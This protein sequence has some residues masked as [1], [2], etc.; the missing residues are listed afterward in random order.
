MPK[1]YYG[2]KNEPAFELEQS[3]NLIVVRTRS[4]KSLTR[5]V[6]SVAQPISAELS[7]GALVVSY[8]EVGVEVYRVPT[9]RHDRSMNDRKAALRAAPDVQFAGGVLVDPT[10][11]Q[12]VL[13]TENIFI[14]F[15]DTAD[16]DECVEIIRNAGLTVKS[17]L[18]YATN[19]YFLEAPAGTG[20]KVF[21]IA[22]NLLKLD[23]VEYCHPELI[24]PRAR[25]QIFPQQWHLKKTAINGL[26][27]DASA[28]VA[29]A[30]EITQGEGV[31]IAVI[32]DGVDIDHPE[33]SGTGKIVAP[34]DATLQIND[35]R[36]KDLFSNHGT[37]CAGVACANGADG[38]SGVA[39]KARLIPIRLASGLGSQQEA[40]A[41][42][43]AADNGADVISCS[44]GPDDGEWWNKN[45]P[46]HREKVQLPASTRL[47]MDYVTQK[48][49]NG[50]GCVILF[51]AG[52]GN[53]SIENDGYASHDK[54]IA[55]TACND[56]G[57]RSV[58]S[59]FGKAAWCAFPS[60][61]FGHAPF[62]HPDP[63]TTGIWTTDRVGRAGYNPDEQGHAAGDSA[64]NYT[65]SFGGTSSSCPGAAGVAAL[66]LAVNPDLKWQEVKALFKR[67]CDKIDPQGGDY[68]TAGHSP[69]YGYGRLNARTAVELA[70]PQP[71]NAV[72][73]SRRFDAPIPDMQSVSYTLEVA[74]DL[75]VE[76]LSVSVDI[77]HT[78]IGD[79]IITLLPPAETGVGTIVLRSRAGGSTKN[80]K[81]T[82]DAFTT[83]ALA[84][85]SGKQCKG[86]WTLQI[87][88]VAAQ[89]F[90]TLVSFGINLVFARSDRVVPAPE[91]K[92]AKAGKKKGSK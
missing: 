86:T 46:V 13:Y 74:D 92:K 29:A 66:V 67:A 70:K 8:P 33:F 83:P 72:T 64:F 22:N 12:P 16:S 56:R 3:D 5:S 62:S 41:F 58:Y 23:K 75:P 32:D 6:G 87:Q 90:G 45:D 25:K 49:R 38:A 91:T 47:A 84:K 37:A 4:G 30:H 44:W 80:L 57:T 69:K 26:T 42:K 24:R 1:I 53:E 20:Q 50:K 76:S 43:W 40:D 36:P 54:V 11:K 31:T 63:L 73:V 35:P 77:L 55:V 48:G 61:D 14:K 10:S 88:D 51:A 79:L 34:R 18:D 9:G 28:N 17:Q 81:Q 7:D 89:D 82:F 39:P 27:V 19:A 59:D 68:N 85:F 52:N 2:T 15:I 21:D 60:S 78:Y 65:N 71:Q